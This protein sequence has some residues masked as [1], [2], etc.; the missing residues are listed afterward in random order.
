MRDKI[1]STNS[2]KCQPM[3]TLP[4]ARD[5]RC[6]D[7]QGAHSSPQH[8]HRLPR[9]KSTSSAWHG[10]HLYQEGGPGCPFRPLDSA[11]ELVCRLY[12]TRRPVG[13][14][15]F[16]SSFL[17]CSMEAAGPAVPSTVSVGLPEPQSITR[18]SSFVTTRISST[19]MTRR[20]STSLLLMMRSGR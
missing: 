14:P 5:R 12:L 3:S 11:A 17:F 10:A 19:S 6:R 2:S 15:C 20:R 7:G 4:G 1:A 13:P 8:P 16:L 18:L 9:C